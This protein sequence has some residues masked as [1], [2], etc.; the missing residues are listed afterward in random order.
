MERVFNWND[1]QFVIGICLYFVSGCLAPLRN[2]I[3]YEI[4][5]EIFVILR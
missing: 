3:F 4:Q 1:L 5:F 2:V